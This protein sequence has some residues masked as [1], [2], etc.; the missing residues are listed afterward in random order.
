[1]HGREDIKTCTH[2]DCELSLTLLAVCLHQNCQW[3]SGEVFRWVI[4]FTEQFTRIDH[5]THFLKL[6]LTTRTI[7]QHSRQVSAHKVNKEQILLASTAHIRE[8][9]LAPSFPETVNLLIVRNRCEDGELTRQV[10]IKGE[11]KTEFL[12]GTAIYPVYTHAPKG[13]RIDLQLWTYLI[14][15]MESL[16]TLMKLRRVF[17]GC[18]LGGCL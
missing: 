1:M 4:A 13:H 16:W 15:L 8:I 18:D 17:S 11:A 12:T 10:T 6:L 14:S 2:A 7:L 9:V 3:Y 5:M